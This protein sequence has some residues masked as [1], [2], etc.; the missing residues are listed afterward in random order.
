MKLYFSGNGIAKFILFYSGPR[1]LPYKT[2]EQEFIFGLLHVLN[3]FRKIRSMCVI[4]DL[5]Y[6][7]NLITLIG[8]NPCSVGNFQHSLMQT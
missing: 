1:K 6:S 2:V 5:Q 8:F 4:V 7:S 3:S